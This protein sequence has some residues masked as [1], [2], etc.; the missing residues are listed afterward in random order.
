MRLINESDRLG[1][2]KL[3]LWICHQTHIRI[4]TL[5]VLNE[6]RNG[7]TDNVWLL[8][9]SLWIYPEAYHEEHNEKA[10][11]QKSSDVSVL[12]S[13]VNFQMQAISAR[14]LGIQTQRAVSAPS[15][16]RY[17][18]SDRCSDSGAILSYSSTSKALSFHRL[19]SQRIW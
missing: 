17:H 13:A 5:Y 15:G 12:L 3:E 14:L 10:S 18:W 1:H 6:L 2:T 4:R 11:C 8:P 7:L 16:K 19:I 9:R